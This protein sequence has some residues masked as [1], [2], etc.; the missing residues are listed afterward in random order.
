MKLWLTLSRNFPPPGHP[1]EERDESSISTENSDTNLGLGS[2][3]STLVNQP[4]PH[5][6]VEIEYPTQTQDLQ[7][8]IS[9]L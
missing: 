3:V 8:Y 6:V 1:E 4:S 5:L 2:A 9:L 7:L